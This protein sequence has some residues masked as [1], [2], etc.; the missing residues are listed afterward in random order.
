[1]AERSWKDGVA[2]VQCT[3][4]GEV[5]GSA[6]PNLRPTAT[7]VEGDPRPNL[8]LERSGRRVA[9]RYVS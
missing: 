3:R 4:G 8:R 2:C 6:P 7:G 9:D 1:M 5:E